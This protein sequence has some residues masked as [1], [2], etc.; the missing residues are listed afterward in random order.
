M[1]KIMNHPNGRGVGWLNPSAREEWQE[2]EAVSATGR[3][4]NGVRTDKPRRRQLFGKFASIQFSDCEFFNGTFQCGCIFGSLLRP[5][6]LQSVLQDFPDV[7]FCAGGKPIGGAHAR[8][9][10]IPV[11]MS[12]TEC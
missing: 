4:C 1:E 5:P 11:Q 9:R 6:F 10:C 7:G 12:E 8:L 2:Q 3:K